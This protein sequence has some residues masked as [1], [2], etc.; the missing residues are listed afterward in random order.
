MATT[1]KV[2]APDGSVFFRTSQT[3]QYTHAVLVQYGNECQ[4]PG[5]WNAISF[6]GRGDL[7]GRERDRWAKNSDRFSAVLVAKVEVVPAKV[8]AAK[9]RAT[10]TTASK[11]ATKLAARLRKM[12]LNAK[13]NGDHVMVAAVAINADPYYDYWNSDA[14]RKA[15]IARIM[16]RNTVLGKG[17][18]RRYLRSLGLNDPC[19]RVFYSYFYA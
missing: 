2:T 11:Q 14:D 7:A 16:L 6:C 12:G 1:F 18:T 15:K 13:K 19:I 4:S 8:R 3:R 17:I 9:V 10:E 5:T